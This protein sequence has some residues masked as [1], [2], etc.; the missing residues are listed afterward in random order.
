MTETNS[1]S[2]A[3]TSYPPHPFKPFPFS[4]PEPPLPFLSLLIHVTLLNSIFMAPQREILYQQAMVEFS[5]M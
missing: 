1:S 3:R 2:P 5:E 4:L